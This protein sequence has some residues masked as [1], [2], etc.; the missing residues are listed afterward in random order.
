MTCFLLEQ[1]RDRRRRRRAAR[2]RRRLGLEN[3]E[4]YGGAWRW[5]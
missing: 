1:W 4:F 3:R 5:R 2:I